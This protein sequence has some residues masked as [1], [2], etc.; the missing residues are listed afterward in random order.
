MSELQEKYNQLLQEHLKLKN[1]YS[2]NTIIES[3]NDMKKVYDIQKKEIDKLG[4]IIYEMTDMTKSTKTMLLV[5]SK[6]INNYGN[7]DFKNRLEFIQEI[8]D[9]SL[10][11]KMNYSI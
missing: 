9:S 1:D 5:L 6:N 10:R 3:M 11:L 2:E 4:R 8:L 7:N